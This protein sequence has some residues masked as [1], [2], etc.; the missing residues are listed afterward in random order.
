MVIS[1][2]SVG[3]GRAGVQ[4]SCR[5][6]IWCETATSGHNAAAFLLWTRERGC[7]IRAVSH[8]LTFHLGRDARGGWRSKYS[9]VIHVPIDTPLLI[10]V[11]VSP[12]Q[13]EALLARPP[14]GWQHRPRLPLPFALPIR[15]LILPTVLL[16]S[17]AREEDVP[18]RRIRHAPDVPRQLVRALGRRPR[19][20]R[21]ARGEREQRGD[22]RWAALV[23]GVPLEPFG[24]L[25]VQ[26]EEG[27]ARVGGRE[28]AAGGGEEVEVSVNRGGRWSDR[29]KRE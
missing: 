12:S 19:A 24:G 18:E 23:E 15:V 27:G 1:V 7:K 13:Y 21:D 11:E 8:H 29:V 6:R 17:V 25:G 2:I 3:G 10:E 4:G 26:G 28:R 5:T 22:D 20:Q 9:P 14:P 16:H